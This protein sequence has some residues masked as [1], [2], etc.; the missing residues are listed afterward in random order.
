VNENGVCDAKEHTQRP[1][2]K[3]VKQTVEVMITASLRGVTR[4]ATLTVKGV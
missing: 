1:E 3:R 2:A 4:S